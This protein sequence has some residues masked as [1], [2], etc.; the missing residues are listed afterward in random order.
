MFK[1]FDKER[2][3]FKQ[4][5]VLALVSVLTSFISS[6]LGPAN[7]LLSLLPMAAC[8][9]AIA[10]LIH[11]E[12]DRCK[13]LKI[14]VP[15]CAIALDWI[16]NGLHSLCGVL[17]VVLALMIFLLYEQKWPKLE[18]ALVMSL[19]SAGMIALIFIAIGATNN[20]GLSVAEFYAETLEE[21]KV[22]YLNYYN[23]VYLPLYEEYGVE[24]LSSEDILYVL[25]L[26]VGIIVSMLFIAG[27]AMVGVACKIY[28]YVLRKC[29]ADNDRLKNWRFIPTRVYAYFY[30]ALELVTMFLGSELTTFNLTVINLSTIFMVVFWYMGLVAIGKFLSERKKRGMPVALTLICSV[31]ISIAFPRIF[32]YVGVFYCIVISKIQK[33]NNTSEE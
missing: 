30:V 1:D 7:L 11:F 10:A 3:N 14:I 16:F 15:V 25:D 21:L 6:L 12:C 13:V 24:A 27:F 23:E 5:L 32:S 18:G 20:Q 4:A 19:V 22:E 29:G 26:V 9:G 33:L 8:A 17:V 2:I 28:S 31:F